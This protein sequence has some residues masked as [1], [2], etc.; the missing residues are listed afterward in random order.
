MDNHFTVDK[1]LELLHQV[2][3][4][5]DRDQGDLARREMI[6]YGKTSAAEYGENSYNTTDAAMPGQDE[7]LPFSTFSLRLLVSLGLFLLLIICDL[8]GKDFF[9]LPASQCFQVISQDYESSITQWVNAAS[10]A[11]KDS[12]ASTDAGNTTAPTDNITK[13]VTPTD[14]ANTTMPADN[15]ANVTTP[16]DNSANVTTPADNSA[17]V[18]TPAD[19]TAY[20]TTP[21]DNSANVTTPADN[22]ANVTT[23]TDSA[24]STTSTKATDTAASKNA[25]D[26]N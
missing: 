12:A 8:S 25:S 6:L 13:V 20:V 3:S 10:H 19:D 11:V 21:A 9:G 16:A 5:Y 2:R 7:A 4:R 17:N 18:T 14:S 23:P 1:K 22:S 24:I 15:T 26:T